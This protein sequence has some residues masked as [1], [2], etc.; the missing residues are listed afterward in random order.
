M[1]IRSLALAALIAC[2][3]TAFAEGD[4]HVENFAFSFD[5]PF[6][7]FDEHQLQRGLQIYTEV[8]AACHGLRYVALRTLTDL[9]Y[10]EGDVRDYSKQYSVVDADTGENRD[11]LPSDHFPANTSVGAP[12]LSLM[13]KARA[14]G[15]DYLASILIGYTGETKEEAGTTFY[16]N[17]TFPGGWI[18]MPPPLEDGKVEFL[19]GHPNT[20]EHMS[21]DVS[22]FLMWTAEPKLVDRRHV[23]FIGALFLTFMAVLFYLT[24][25]RIWA[26]IKGR[27][28]V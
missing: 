16:A 10:P 15:P 6:G 14:G 23:G 2:T 19:D 7:T 3:G 26:G 9:G 21:E 17:K 22:A 4:S 27:R 20:V 5:G 1:K 13:A 18:A 8:C 24:N 25:K 12:D 28:K 11:A